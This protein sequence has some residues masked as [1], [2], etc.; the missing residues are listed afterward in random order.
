M[1][2]DKINIKMVKALTM[3]ANVL[4]VIDTVNT[5]TKI[6]LE[7]QLN[8]LT[9]SSSYLTSMRLKEEMK[10]RNNKMIKRKNTEM[11]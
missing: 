11:M 9:K 10:I 6:T 4:N 3:H 2:K 1:Y 5:I 8:L 7:M